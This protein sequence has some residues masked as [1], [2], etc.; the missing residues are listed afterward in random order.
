METVVRVQ[1]KSAPEK[2]VLGFAKKLGVRPEDLRLQTTPKGEYHT[3]LRKVEGR[4][5]IDILA[6]A[7]PDIILKIT[8]PKSMYWTTERWPAL[9]SADSLDCGVARR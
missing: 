9:H 2:A 3:Y 1:T 5:T 7:L 4:R 8:F 6:E